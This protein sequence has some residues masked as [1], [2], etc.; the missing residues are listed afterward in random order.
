[1]RIAHYSQGV[2]VPVTKVCRVPIHPPICAAVGLAGRLGYPGRSGAGG[3]RLHRRTNATRWRLGELRQ[4]CRRHG[5][6]RD[7]R[8]HRCRRLRTT[9]QT[10]RTRF[11][12]SA[13]HAVAVGQVA[14][15]RLA[16]R[17]RRQYGQ[18]QQFADRFR[19]LQP[20][21]RRYV[22]P[23]SAAARGCCSPPAPNGRVSSFLRGLFPVPSSAR[24]VN[25]R[26]MFRRLRMAE[27]TCRLLCANSN[28]YVC[29]AFTDGWPICLNKAKRKGFIILFL[30]RFFM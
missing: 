8:Q 29:V 28:P 16:L 1:M 2:V 15:A 27:V 24:R 19:S 18:H 14:S 21:S 10:S 5:R 6:R 23:G 20:A 25:A 11:R 3:I 9:R 26:S 7:V 22:A 4:L 13:A 17:P 30:L 12:T